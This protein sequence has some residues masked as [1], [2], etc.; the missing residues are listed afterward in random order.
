[1]YEDIL[2]TLS[3]TSG[4]NVII[5]GAFSILA[6]WLSGTLVF[7]KQ[8]KA[9]EQLHASILYYDL[10]SIENFFTSEEKTTSDILY[11]A[12]WQKS[13]AY[14][15]LIPSDIIQEMYNVYVQVYDFNWRKRNA[16]IIKRDADKDYKD[17]KENTCAALGE[18]LPVFVDKYPH[19]V[20]QKAARNHIFPIM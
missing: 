11:A 7:E 19:I 5:T 6:A 3:A 8:K 13:L 16:H 10:K 9:T 18:I 15:T 4:W 1:M 12:D 14:C 17:A 20:R 2:Q